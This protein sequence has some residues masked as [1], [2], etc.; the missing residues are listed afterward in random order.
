M[1]LAVTGVMVEDQPTLILHDERSYVTETPT[2]LLFA[3]D[4]P[5]EVWGDLTDRLIRAHKRLEFAIADAINFGRRYGERYGNWVHET[6]LSTSTL[7]TIAYVGRQIDV[8]R[9]RQ[10]ISFSHH[11]E[12]APLPPK[13]QDALLDLAVDNGWKREEL[14]DAARQA[15]AQIKLAERALLAVPVVSDPHVHLEVGDA[16]ALDLANETVDLIVTSPPYALSKSYVG[17]DV[18]AADWQAFM[19][20][21]LSEAYRVARVGGRLALN[22]PLDTSPEYGSRPTYAEALVAARRA[23]WVYRTTIV[24]HDNQL[25][26]STARGSLDSASSPYIYFPGEMILLMRKGAEWG[27]PDPGH[28]SIMD[29]QAWLDWTNGHWQISGESTPWEDHP[30]PFPLEVPRRLIALLSFPDD[31]VIDPFL[32][33]GTTALAAVEAGRHFYGCD[34]SEAYVRSAQRRLAR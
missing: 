9:R 17:G 8:C 27:R 33:S 5:F 16:R 28:I 2:G 14:R 4:T 31:L 13:M 32:G 15:R 11:A 18:E 1:T 30:A 24:W 10:D 22:I 21:W 12:V 34:T 3:E 19:L 23:G 7:N 20:A 26:Q 25:G 29:H 6:Q